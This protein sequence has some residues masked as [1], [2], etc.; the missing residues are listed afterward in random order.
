MSAAKSRIEA[1]P[2]AQC[3]AACLIPMRFAAQL[4]LILA[5]SAMMFT[6]DWKSSVRRFHVLSWA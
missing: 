1:T 5:G 4:A 3:G 6:A 2:H